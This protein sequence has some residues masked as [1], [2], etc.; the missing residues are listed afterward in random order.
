[1]IKPHKWETGDYIVS[2]LIVAVPLGIALAIGAPWFVS[3]G[4]ALIGVGL[5]LLLDLCG[6]WAQKH[7][8]KKAAEE[9]AV[10]WAK[11]SQEHR[12]ALQLRS[13]RSR[14]SKPKP[15]DRSRN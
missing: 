10:K 6:R 12:K 13:D 14:Q 9:A 5:V 8:D 7:L 1:M 11:D 15:V 3:L 4:C 2:A